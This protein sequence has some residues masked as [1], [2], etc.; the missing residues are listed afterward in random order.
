LKILEKHIVPE[1]DYHIRLQEYAGDVFKKLQT[2]SAVKKAI[3]KN[4]LLIDGKTSKTSDWIQSGMIIE[5]I[6]PKT[7][8]KKIFKLPIKIIFED[9]DIAIINKPSG[10]PTNGNYFKT[11]ENALPFNLKPSK[12]EE[13]LL[14]PKPVHRLD[15]ATSGILLIAKT[16]TALLKLHQQF[17]DKSIQ[18]TYHAVISGKLPKNGIIN[19]VIKNQQAETSYTS[20][21]QVPSLQNKYLSLVELHPKTGRTHQL[22]IHLSTLGFPIIG[23]K[24]YAEK[25]IMMHKGLFLCATKIEFKHPISDNKLSFEIDLPLKFNNYLQRE[26]NRFLK[27]N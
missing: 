17:K 22:R 1:G 9:D 5:L 23:D 12:K 21:K 4:I 15:N 3:N 24:L 11:I 2:R 13:T 19:T 18:K 25:N 20:I 16:K 26:N 10:Y 6:S 7:S 27:Y 8:P 14:F